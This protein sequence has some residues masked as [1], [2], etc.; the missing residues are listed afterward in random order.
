MVERYPI[1][2]ISYYGTF[3]F[4][5]LDRFR[6]CIEKKGWSE[7]KPNSISGF[8]TEELEKYVRKYRG[9]VIWGLNKQRGTEEA[10]LFFHQKSK[11]IYELFE[12]IRRKIKRLAEKLDAPTSLSIGMVRGAAPLI[13]QIKSHN[14][15]EF[16]K[17]PN[18][19]MAYRALKKAKK[20]GGNCIVQL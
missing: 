5:D 19:L 12:N 11:I 6:N 13:K 15:K 1:K 18:I 10:I 16:K 2:K 4:L 20:N 9:L 17:D 7:F 8:L 3:V 14:K